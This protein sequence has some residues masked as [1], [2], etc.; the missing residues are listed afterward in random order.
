M[1]QLADRTRAG[2]I[3]QKVGSR[4]CRAACRFGTVARYMA[5]SNNSG[6]SFRRRIHSTRMTLGR[7]SWK[8]RRR[9]AN[10]QQNMELIKSQEKNVGASRGSATP[11]QSPARCWSRGAAWMSSMPKSSCSRRNRRNCKRFSATIR[12]SQNS[13]GP[14]AR[15]YLYRVVR[16]SGATCDA[17][18]DL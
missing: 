11:R 12:P 17:I 9:I 2:T 10:L 1:G 6:R 15:K 7:L 18:E 13:T 3:F 16:Q 4:R 8:C 14:R 5:R